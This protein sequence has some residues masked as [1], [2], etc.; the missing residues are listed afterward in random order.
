MPAEMTQRLRPSIALLLLTLLCGCTI[1]PQR[2]AAWSN[3]TGAEQFERLWWQAVK[4][5]NWN[6]VEQRLSGTYAAQI[7][8]KTVDREQMLERLR[9][10]AISDFSL[11]DVSVQPSGDATVISYSLDL[12]SSTGEQHIAMMSVWQRQKR[13][14]VQIA[15]S[16]ARQ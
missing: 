4:D 2:T 14:W 3:A 1:W 6:E 5:K 7:E 15:H 9:Q 12:R 16:E 13:G 8:G 11:G 10:L